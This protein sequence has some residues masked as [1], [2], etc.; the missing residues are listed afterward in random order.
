[1]A[2]AEPASSEPSGAE[3]WQCE[4]CAKAA[5]FELML[6]KDLKCSCGEEWSPDSFGMCDLK[7][8]ELYWTVGEPRQKRDGT[9]VVSVGVQ[10]ECGGCG[11]PLIFDVDFIVE[12]VEEVKAQE[13]EGK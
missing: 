3:E 7:C 1:M 11:S 12:T 5:K 9:R 2:A 8:R 6:R 13:E 10:D 4:G